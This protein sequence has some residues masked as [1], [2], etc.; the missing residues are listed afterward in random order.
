MITY[1]SRT[2]YVHNNHLAP[3]GWYMI[4]VQGDQL[5]FLPVEADSSNSFFIGFDWYLTY[6]I[7]GDISTVE[8]ICGE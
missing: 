8:Q 2:H 7:T 6:L 1:N 4:T 5:G 3:M